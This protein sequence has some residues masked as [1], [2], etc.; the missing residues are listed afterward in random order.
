LQDVDIIRELYEASR[1]GVPI[2]LNVRGLCCLRP[3]V[4]GLSE[5]VRVFGVIGR[6]LEHSRI[7]R[8]RNGGD[9]EYFLGSADWMKR[10]LSNRVETIVPV[11][12]VT[13]QREIDAVLDVYEQDNASAWDCD[14]DGRYV[15]RRPADGAPARA[16]QDVLARR[17]ACESDP[18][19]VGD[20]ATTGV[21]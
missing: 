14:A 9:P 16:A 1:A 15:L 12:D 13:L 17:A 7:Y 20:L 3:G 6:F 10:N 2:R 11:L 19:G 5:T 8:F 4:P 21:R 18:D